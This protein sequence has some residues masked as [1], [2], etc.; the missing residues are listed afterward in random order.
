MQYLV[1]SG[2]VFRKNRVIG[3]QEGLVARAH[4]EQR[5]QMSCY[6]MIFKT[7]KNIDNTLRPWGIIIRI[8]ESGGS[9]IVPFPT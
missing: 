5:D 1:F 4:A 7:A 2:K 8:A 3:I 6:A 9:I